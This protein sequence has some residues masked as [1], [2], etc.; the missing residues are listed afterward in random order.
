MNHWKKPLL[1]NL[2][3]AVALLLF[4]VATGGSGDGMYVP[5]FALSGILI[6][7]LAPVNFII[8]MVRNRDKKGDGPAYLVVSGILLLIGFSVCTI[9]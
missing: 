4:D 2:L 9:N 1:I 3:I 5:R 7:L 8:G 6:L